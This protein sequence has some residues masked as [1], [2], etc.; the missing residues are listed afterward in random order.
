MWLLDWLAHTTKSMGRGELLGWGFE[1]S[2][3]TCVMSMCAH[4]RVYNAG[5]GQKRIPWNWRCRRL[6]YLLWMLGTG[7]QST[8]R[9]AVLLASEPSRQSHGWGTLEFKF[10]ASHRLSK[11]VLC[12]WTMLPASQKFLKCDRET[13]SMGILRDVQAMNLLGPSP[14]LWNQ[15]L[16]VWV[17]GCAS[18]GSSG[19]SDTC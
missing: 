9:A 18:V 15:R 6:S 1:K 12:H 16:W 7:L 19:D 8:T 5:G 10:M 14:C 13:S 4:T 2:N 17:P 11:Q 3:H